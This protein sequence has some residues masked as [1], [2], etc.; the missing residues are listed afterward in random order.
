[1]HIKRILSLIMAI[2]MLLSVSVFAQETDAYVYVAFGDSIAAGYG[3]S[4]Y[5]LETD[6]SDMD[7]V[8]LLAG[9]SQ[10]IDFT[11]SGM[12]TN[13]LLELVAQAEVV[14][15][16]KKA[17]L[18]TI[19]IGGNDLIRPLLQAVLPDVE[20][21][22]L[23][24]PTMAE[25]AGMDIGA[26]AE[27]IGLGD[28]NVILPA[29]MEVIGNV[30]AITDETYA[31]VSGIIAA[32]KA[33]NPEAAVLIQTVY[34]PYRGSDLLMGYD[35]MLDSVFAVLNA[36]ITNA[37]KENGA[38]VADVFT[39]FVPYGA[40]LLNSSIPELFYDP[41]PTY[42]GHVVIAETVEKTL[43]AA[44]VALP[45]GRATLANKLY[46]DV[47][48]GSKYLEAVETVTDLGLMNGVG[49]GKF[50]PNDTLNRAMVVTVL[51][52]IA[53]VEAAA[54]AGFADV[55]AGAWYESAVNW[56]A[57][58]GIVTGY[59]DGTFRPTDSVTREQ[60]AALLYRYF[61]SPEAAEGT[62]EAIDAAEAGA[63]A[64][65]ALKWAVE[66]GIL[67]VDGYGRLN[68]K[69]LATRGETAYGVA[70]AVAAV[71]EK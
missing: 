27:E 71:S 54:S 68:P 2:V 34:N 18:V 45:E 57:A 25:N 36:K 28:L 17:D 5:D 69:G 48:G 47:T 11:A 20:V 9:N 23:M 50:G 60:L 14:D 41:H 59:D 1:M 31:N 44:G 13:E 38:L 61:G 21:G 53:P 29:I 70:A 65:D 52:R 56:G 33:A 8:S 40:V 42:N 63:W 12:A 58:S 55:P 39:A 4:D 10:L 35:S 22:S 7:Y 30:E 51:S 46:S 67:S 66:N 43:T 49:D 64:V 24:I 26:M 3:L 62:L 19:S 32:I 6:T 16:V 37:S 15:S